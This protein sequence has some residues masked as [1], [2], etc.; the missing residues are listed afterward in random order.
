MNVKWLKTGIKANL[1]KEKKMKKNKLN[2]NI[3]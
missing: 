3:E 1:K 2:A